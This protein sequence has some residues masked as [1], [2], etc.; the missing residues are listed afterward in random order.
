MHRAQSHNPWAVKPEAPVDP[1][2]V[3]EREAAR[4]L[5][6]SSKT[7]FKWRQENMV[8]FVRIGSM[9]RYKVEDL[10]ALVDKYRQA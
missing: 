7:L 2:M 3:T 8:P 10:I 1:I 6:V 5:G 9:V 4:R